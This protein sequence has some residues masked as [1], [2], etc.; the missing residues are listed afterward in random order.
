MSAR[1]VPAILVVA[2]LLVVGATPLVAQRESDKSS[3][4]A[5]QQVNDAIKDV[6]QY[7]PFEPAHTA[8]DQTTR[9]TDAINNGTDQSS[10]GSSD[11]KAEDDH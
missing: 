10:S 2:A 11:A 7:I 8:I 9:E 5:H 4:D 1:H 6:N 3:D